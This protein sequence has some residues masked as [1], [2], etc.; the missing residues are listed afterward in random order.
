MDK[1]PVIQEVDLA[2]SD[3]QIQVRSRDYSEDY[4]QWGD[5][6]IA[7]GAIIHPGYLTFDPL[8][9]EAFRAVVKLSLTEQFQEDPLAQRR[10]IIPFDV[11]DTDKLELLSVAE[12]VR[13]E[14]PLVQGRY[15]LYYEICEDQEIYFQMT[16]V[17]AEE[18]IQARFLMDD[19]WGGEKDQPLVEGYR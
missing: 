16:F 17:P 5:D 11:M 9:E 2:I 13:I 7:Q 18:A 8:T 15:A 14:L 6:N 4:C 10:M 3:H 12:R 19:E 1:Q